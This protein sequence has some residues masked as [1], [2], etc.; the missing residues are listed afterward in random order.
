MRMSQL[1]ASIIAL[2][3]TA[4]FA[5]A[6]GGTAL[7]YQGRLLDAGEPA[8]GLFDFEFGLWDALSGGSQLDVTNVLNNVQVTDGLFTVQIDFGAD[9]F[10]NADRWL[11]IT[12]DGVPLV[13]RQPITRSPYSIQTRG[14][15][16]DQDQYV[17]I[18]T[19]APS[20]RLSLSEQLRLFDS[21]PPGA[22]ASE[23]GYLFGASIPSGMVTEVSGQL[24]DFAVNIP[25]IGLRDINRVGGLVR[26][27]TRLKASRES[28]N[29]Q[30]F[31]VGSNTN[32]PR[33]FINL[34]TGQTNLA[35][36]GG[37]VAI[38]TFFDPIHPLEMASGAHVTAG[39]VWTD[40][41]DANRKE[42]INPVDARAILDRVRDLPISTW[43]FKDENESIRHLGPMAQDFHA[44]F[45]LGADDKHLASLD[46]GG[47]ALA[48]IQGLYE[49]VQEKD[50]EITD[51]KARLA[52][53][54]ALIERLAV[55]RNEGA[56]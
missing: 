44:A 55:D 9:A 41:S 53:L 8:N 14:I 45:A 56:P 39:G 34:N 10:N 22:V 47:V 52:A 31:P 6:G 4:R 35:P 29:I 28:F 17:G 20:A 37:N 16:V 54:E 13:P 11:D 43:N 38:G 30:G 3:L 15:F 7:T 12:V 50:H 42:N 26:I 36:G 5:L 24:L 21:T 25:V 51:L 1:A 46:S 19:T 40:T 23:A 33:L 2:A 27:D 49:L 32:F 18:G 48:A